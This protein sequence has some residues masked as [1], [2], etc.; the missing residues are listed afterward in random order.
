[1]Q[2]KRGF[3]LTELLVVIVIIGILSAVVLPKF[4]KMLEARKTT[5]AENI[6]TAVRSEQEARCSLDT[7][8]ATTTADLKSWPKNGSKNFSFSVTRSGITARNT[9]GDYA[10][11]MP[12]YRD[13]RICC[14]GDGCD[15]LNKNYMTCQVLL[16]KP[17][18]KPADESCTPGDLGGMDDPTWQ[19]GVDPGTNPA[20]CKVP[21]PATQSR[22][23]GCTNSGTKT[24]TFD[25]G[26]CKWGEWTNCSE[27]ETDCDPDCTVP[28]ET[29]QTEKCGCT[30][31][32]TRT[33]TFDE[34]TCKWGEWTD[35]T[36][37]DTDCDE[38][39]DSHQED[40]IE[41]EEQCDCNTSKYVRWKCVDGK[42]T[43]YDDEK[44]C[45]DAEREQDECEHDQG[46]WD[47]DTCKCDA[48]CSDTVAQ[49]HCEQ[50]VGDN[51]VA[52]TW[53]EDICDCDC[54]PGTTKV[55]MECVKEGCKPSCD[56]EEETCTR[57]GGLNPR[58]V[59]G[60]WD[61]D[62]CRCICPSGAKWAGCVDG[63]V[64]GSCEEE[65]G[66][67]LIQN[68]RQSC[69]T[70]NGPMSTTE[71]NLHGCGIPGS[72][73]EVDCVCNCPEGSHMS[74]TYEVCCD[75][76]GKP[77][78]RDND[79]QDDTQDKPEDRYWELYHDGNDEGDWDSDDG[80]W[81]YGGDYG[82]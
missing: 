57:G 80:G 50:P 32:G 75:N 48:T 44:D 37:K 77:D 78:P 16:T 22:N 72:W 38:C 65:Y 28:N 20:G 30:E 82:Y 79:G 42:W 24:R 67:S 39:D 46:K 61:K 36:E 81:D 47:P 69:E 4:N 40:E 2:R 33:R 3:T 18:Y 73:N 58:S 74:R 52:G 13:G 19:E 76:R 27:K 62:N 64:N 29:T 51:S 25:Q 53:N 60:T 26:A 68:L 31:S 45:R 23:C 21:S 43:H 11:E 49:Q 14:S 59:P 56:Y 34:A 71:Q 7:E 55:D 9:E 15:T 6:M 70:G 10:L 1:M 5:E 63:C 12:S 54:P 35:C 17:D 41:S 8:Y 66:A